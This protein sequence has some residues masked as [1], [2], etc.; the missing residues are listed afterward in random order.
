MRRKS[1]FISNILGFLIILIF[2]V[3]I[4]FCLDIFGIISVPEKYSLTTYLAPFIGMEVSELSVSADL[5][6]IV[7]EDTIDEWI[8]AKPKVIDKKY[9]AD[10]DNSNQEVISII[11][12]TV[13]E[14]N[15]TKPAIYQ[16][17]NVVNRLYFSQLDVYGKLIYL[18]LIE[19]KD[20]LIHGTYVADFG[21][22]FNELLHQED[23]EE[24]LENAFHL[25]L[26][27]LMYD[28]PELF[29]I[30]ITKMFMSTEITSFGPLKTYRVKIGPAENS[31]YL[32]NYFQDEQ[33]VLEAN[34]N[35]NKFREEIA[36]NFKS[37]S[38]YDKIDKI[39]TYLIENTKYDESLSK[40]NIYNIYGALTDHIAV[41]EG[42]SKAMKY[43]LDAAN[44]PCVIACGI[45]QN[46]SGQRESH[47]WNYVKIDGKW[48][49]IDST[50]DDPVIV[51]YGYVSS[52][53]HTK[54]F[55][56]GSN[57]FF[58]DHFEDG[59]IVCNSNFVYP[60]ISEENYNR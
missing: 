11:N 42:Y 5:E 32:S 4:Y 9:E 38:D 17:D 59:N 39:H 23:G 27:S 8:N 36:S 57:D 53:I 54:Y 35:L 16:N 56:R 44:V 19:H 31:N 7:T 43:M 49:A 2:F 25:S 50:W 47:A 60:T 26:N 40:S 33:F 24:T 15:Q 28:N 21:T 10:E 14:Q 3:T 34:N 52:S 20:E 12:T 13:G 58:K 22:D 29:Y 55:L 1:N 48:Y 51:G 45:A 6:G 37:L 18:Q 41:C 46:T 30:D